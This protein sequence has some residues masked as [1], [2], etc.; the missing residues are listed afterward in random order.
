MSAKGRRLLSLNTYAS[1][2][3][4]W[5][6]DDEKQRRTANG[7]DG[8]S[9]QHHKIGRYAT[10]RHTRSQ[11]AGVLKTILVV[12]AILAAALFVVIATRYAQLPATRAGA[13]HTS[14]IT[15]HDDR[16]EPTIPIG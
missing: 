8:R 14:T 1:R 6:A 11:S 4:G 7:K 5:R 10:P 9:E 13:Q 15:A 16:N 3:Q 2:P 12:A